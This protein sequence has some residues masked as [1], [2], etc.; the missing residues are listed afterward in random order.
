[1]PH[2]S[3][4]RLDSPPCPPPLVWSIPPTSPQAWPPPGPL[5]STPARPPLSPAPLSPTAHASAAGVRR[6][7]SAELL[8]PLVAAGILFG[9]GCATLACLWVRRAEISA[10]YRRN[11]RR[12]QSTR[13]LATSTGEYEYPFNSIEDDTVSAP[14]DLPGRAPVARGGDGQ[15]ATRGPTSTHAD[16]RLDSMAFMLPPITTPL[17]PGP[18]GATPPQSPVPNRS[19]GLTETGRSALARAR[20]PRVCSKGVAHNGLTS[21]EF[22]SHVSSLEEEAV[23]ET[24]A[25]GP[26]GQRPASSCVIAL[27]APGDAVYADAT[28]PCDAGATIRPPTDA[29]IEDPGAS[30]PPATPPTSSARTARRAARR[31]RTPHQLNFP[32]SPHLAPPAHIAPSTPTASQGRSMLRLRRSLSTPE[33]TLYRIETL[34]RDGAPDDACDD[35][36]LTAMASLGVLGGVCV[37]GET[38]CPSGSAMIVPSMCAAVPPS[39]H[40]PR[41]PQHATAAAGSP[42]IARLG[43]Q[44]RARTADASSA[45]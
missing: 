18:T 3:P 9:C 1:M 19:H 35:D 41:G 7:P 11:Q 36:G 22:W 23:R 43:I 34:G 32:P 24:D 44:S 6:E 28:S 20:A 31:V 45:I 40:P 39:L 26:I 13:D 16:G 27:P 21:P 38:S 25:A 5:P 10:R 17:P 12:Q 37:E 33:A 29:S 2:Q 30:T 8:F 15:A 42:R 14:T 4:A